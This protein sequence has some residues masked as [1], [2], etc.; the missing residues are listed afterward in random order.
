MRIAYSA[1][2]PEIL[3]CRKKIIEKWEIKDSIAPYWRFYINEGNGGEIIYNDHKIH[4]LDSTIY[5][6]TPMTTFKTKCIKKHT[7]YFLHFKLPAPYNFISPDVFKIDT[8]LSEMVDIMQVFR[9]WPES[10][11]PNFNFYLQYV[12]NKSLSQLPHNIW[13]EAVKDYRIDDILRFI[14]S[15]PYQKFS[16]GD[17][18][19]RSNLAENSFI[20]L[21]KNEIGVPP[22]KFIQ[23]QKLGKAVTLLLNE[24]WTIDTISETCGFAN[25]SHFSHLFRKA[26][27]LS[28]AS[29]RFINR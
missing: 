1:L 22:Q 29:F 3:V 28:P 8:S 4:L 11:S 15:Y 20:R 9:S 21:F 13:P 16:N 23:Q 7:S 25:R 5:L 2:K 19:K 10:P 17:L 14:E 27:H 26:F 12:L 24:N 6:I 18:A